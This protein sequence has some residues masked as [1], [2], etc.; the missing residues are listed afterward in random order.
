VHSLL[1]STKLNIAII[2]ISLASLVVSF[3][4]LSW[5]G[6]K[7]TQDV[8]QSTSKELIESANYKMDCKVR[9]GIT[10]AI[11]IGNDKRIQT[12]LQTNERKYA[13]ESLKDI[14]IKMKEHTE[15]QNIK[16]QIHT[17]NNISF[18]RNWE[19]EKYGDDLSSFRASV[20]S[21]NKTL[22]PIT[23]LEV[24]RAGLNLRSVIPIIGDNEEHLG[25]LEFIQGVDS[26]AKDFDKTSVGFLLLMDG[27][28][29][30]MMSGG[31]KV[32]FT[33][34]D[35]FQSYIISQKFLNKDF[36]SDAKNLDM[37]NLLK[38]GYTLSSKYFYTFIKVKDFQDKELGIILLAKPL[39]AVNS[40]IDKSHIL[41]Y[42]SL[43]GILTMAIV[44]TL[45]IMFA[46]KK[47][48]TQPL[49]IF[50]DGLSSFFLF[51][52][53][54]KDYTND[55]AIYT[56]DEF[57]T[58]ANS[59][60]ENIAVSAKLHEEINELNTNL[61]Y[62]VEE[63]TQKISALLDNAGQG[64][65][66]FGC[67][68]IID[69]E[70][71]AEC[72][73]FLGEDIAGKNIADLLFVDDNKKEFFQN[74]IL[75]INEMG[76]DIIKHSLLSLLPTEIILNK[77]ALKLEYKFL[78][79]EKL[80]L[81]I[82]NISAQKKLENKVE[83]EQTTLKMI[84]EVVTQS[85]IYFE[86]KKEYEMFIDNYKNQID[87]SKTSLHNIND[88]YRT[89]HTFKGAFSQLHMRHIVTFLH[90]VESELSSMLKET[91]H[92]NEKL[93][94][95]LN[96]YDFK[97]SWHVELDIIKNILGEE[98][99]NSSSFVKINLSVIKTLENKIFKLFEQSNLTTPQAKEIIT[100][101]AS[102]SN[103]SLLQML[104]TY[105]S[106]VEQL[107]IKLEKHIYPFEIIG[108]SY[109]LVSEKV[110]PF[111]KS[112]IHVFRNA[113]D[114]GI[115]TPETRDENEKD[116]GGTISC[117]FKETGNII[118][119]IISDDGSGIDKEKIVEKAFN[120]GMITKEQKSSLSDEEIYNFIFSEQFSTKDEI[121]ETSGRGVG[122]SAV[123]TELEKI[124]GTI[125]INTQKNL[126][127]T[128]IFTIPTQEG[129]I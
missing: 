66:S 76:N 19:P 113:I 15:F 99:F 97:S 70:Y 10:N 29:N 50:E 78:G 23:S 80:M 64:F 14:S 94:S 79:D 56:D 41:I 83:K 63:K 114:H 38:N 52:Q 27:K 62:K 22:K 105:P 100:E 85:D 82:T 39:S 124:G 104:K 43:L 55:I 1:V 58:M 98:F 102:L 110:K 59:L 37:Q 32:L 30:D 5:Y 47:L 49:K 21:V 116:T 31:E 127:T 119:I 24:G 108:D 4:L 81:V 106:L 11:S 45:V 74:T 25:S 123:K 6:T 120:E 68:F 96:K 28:I 42:I 103:Q 17:K 126:G 118:E 72:K 87:V 3:L 34:G 12:A 71:S 18:L 36:M 93:L 128:F 112:L 51:L 129:E 73:R 44:I 46:V 107:A 7:I 90:S 75:D 13:I 101:V 16:V 53:G 33:E 115:E 26:V 40:V 9:I 109:V 86:T 8:Y 117:S 67:D 95:L 57:G 65:L 92:T 84:V 2:G 69:N 125:K 20:V 60:R 61:E 35:K 111:V 77:R 54:K 88:I 91:K 89:I 48:V 122:M 121:T